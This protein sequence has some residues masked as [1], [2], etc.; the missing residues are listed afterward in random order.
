MYVHIELVHQISVVR[1]V[2]SAHK[3][4]IVQLSNMVSRQS[5][6]SA[7][8]AM[9]LVSVHAWDNG[10]ARTPPM[11]WCSWNGFHRNFNDIIVIWI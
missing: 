1:I 6:L 10:L 9:A 8:L 5:C 4:L 7:V 3:P 2:A 11:G